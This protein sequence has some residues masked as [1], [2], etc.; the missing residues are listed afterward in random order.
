MLSLKM[1]SAQQVLLHGATDIFR[2]KCIS[3]K[4][5]MPC[6]QCTPSNE[7]L[8]DFV[9]RGQGSR[10]GTVMSGVGIKKWYPG[11]ITDPTLTKSKIAATR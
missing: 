9:E 3:S 1:S 6:K 4:Q 8:W 7:S 5:Q 11:I 10:H 2:M